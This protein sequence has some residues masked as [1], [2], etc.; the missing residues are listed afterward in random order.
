MVSH[1]ATVVMPTVTTGLGDDR[2][3]GNSI[4][5]V[6]NGLLYRKTSIPDQPRLPPSPAPT[7]PQREEE[8]AQAEGPQQEDVD[9]AD[10]T[11]EVARSDKGKNPAAPLDDDTETLE[12]IEDEW[13]RYPIPSALTSALDDLPETILE[14]VRIST[15]N[16]AARVAEAEM[17]RCEEEEARRRA[18]DE[19][20]VEAQ[21]EKEKGK[22]KEIDYFP[23]IIPDPEAEKKSSE[24]E[25]ASQEKEWARRRQA[26]WAGK[27]GFDNGA[28]SK[29]RG[30]KRHKYS[31]SRMLGLIGGNDK[32]EP[33]KSG[34]ANDSRRKGATETAAANALGGR[35]AILKQL[36]V[37]TA[38]IPARKS[39]E[40]SGAN[41][42]SNMA[43]PD[44]DALS[45]LRVATALLQKN[46]EDPD[47]R[48]STV[49]SV[50]RRVKGK[51]RQVIRDDVGEA[52]GDGGERESHNDRGDAGT[53][54]SKDG[55]T[56]SQS[57]GD[58][59]GHQ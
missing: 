47:R 25:L 48:R 6:D 24:E 27:T 9:E 2:A 14:I 5:T 30:H 35:D 4:G 36:G 20:E 28:G 11:A 29:Q 53:V 50:R 22:E 13:M 43:S 21:K 49:R 42:L 55:Q 45:H 37:G 54:Q 52:S 31:V 39:N 44:I 15:E 46:F 23:I 40:F 56:E 34:A 26:A 19:A 59:S 3:L 38:M 58:S 10:T 8:P 18:R 17:R 57:D 32:G 12:E 51:A 16:V 41:P 1:T 33:A 7:E